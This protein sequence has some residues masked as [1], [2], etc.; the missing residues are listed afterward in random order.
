MQLVF[1]VSKVIVEAGV[2]SGIGAFGVI[3][4]QVADCEFVHK[5]DE[6]LMMLSRQ[7]EC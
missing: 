3:R 5:L 6:P 7:V 1:H 4:Q 2:L